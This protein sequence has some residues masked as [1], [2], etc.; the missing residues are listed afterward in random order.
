[1]SDECSI[2]LCHFYSVAMHDAHTQRQMLYTFFLIVFLFI[3][4]FF[5][6]LLLFLF[7]FGFPALSSFP[8]LILLL[9][10]TRYCLH[11]RDHECLKKNMSHDI[12]FQ[13]ILFIVQIWYMICLCW[14]SGWIFKDIV[15]NVISWNVQRSVH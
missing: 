2:C 9:N 14:H 6:F 7:L 12:F 8:R 1:M 11:Q 3:I 13:F 4:F 5:L 10:V 15:L